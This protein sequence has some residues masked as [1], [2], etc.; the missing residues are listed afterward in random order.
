MK[1]YCTIYDDYGDHNFNVHNFTQFQSEP[2]L[3]ICIKLE[4]KKMMITQH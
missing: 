3:S 4:K 1:R 2:Y